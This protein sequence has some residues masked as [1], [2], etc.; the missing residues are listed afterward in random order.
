MLRKIVHPLGSSPGTALAWGAT[1]ITL[2]ILTM[3]GRARAA[4]YDV[5]VMC[6]VGVDVGTTDRMDSSSRRFMCMS[7]GV[8]RLRFEVTD[9]QLPKHE[10]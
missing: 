9:T 8:K 1:C 7:A 6:G 4:G 5:S 2:D 3:S 10:H